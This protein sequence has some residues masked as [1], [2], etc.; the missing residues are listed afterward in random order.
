M[1]Q[2]R[3]VVYDTLTWGIENGLFSQ[4]DRV[5]DEAVEADASMRSF[6]LVTWQPRDCRLHIGNYK[7]NKGA[8]SCE[9]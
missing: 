8:G 5:S 7:I 1:R 3:R 4:P 2:Q 9:A 6:L